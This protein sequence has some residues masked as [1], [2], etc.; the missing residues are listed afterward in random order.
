MEH[1]DDTR[2]EQ[3]LAQIA[4]RFDYPPTPSLAAM[5]GSRPAA[6]STGGRPT[7]DGRRLA[8]GLAILA[9]VGLALLAAPPTRAAILSFFARVGAIDIFI[10]E[11]APPAP[12]PTAAPA[13]PQTATP[14]A[15]VGHSLSLIALG[16]PTTAAEAARRLGFAPHVPAALGAPDEVYL[17]RDVDLPAVTL[18]WRGPDGAPL[19][20]TQIAVA[21]FARKMVSQGGV[22]ETTV[23]GATAMWLPGPH[24]LLLF[25]DG[26]PNADLIASN[27]LI[28]V[29]DGYTFRLEGDLTPAEARRIAESVAD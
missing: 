24:R 20:L 12:P 5:R 27:V 8:W 15:G 21:E 17:H 11:S 28:W 13:T 26:P 6:S 2:W 1:R 22:Q 9:L 19:S 23:N 18:V 7:G 4:R 10:D 3:S 29:S 16:E 14:V 25:G